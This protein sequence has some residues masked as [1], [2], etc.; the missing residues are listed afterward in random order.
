MNIYYII[1]RD[2]IR[3]NINIMS[4][5]NIVPGL[6]TQRLSLMFLMFFQF[7]FKCLLVGN[8]PPICIFLVPIYVFDLLIYNIFG[9]VWKPLMLSVVYIGKIAFWSNFLFMLL[10]IKIHMSYFHFCRTETISVCLHV[11]WCGYI[12][13]HFLMLLLP[14]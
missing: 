3:H 2:K 10:W 9:F 4:A 8:I 6:M 12:Y 14:L 7:G 5:W 1:P 13:L 11:V